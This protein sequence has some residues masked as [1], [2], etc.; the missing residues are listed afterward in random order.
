AILALINP[1]SNNSRK[2]PAFGLKVTQNDTSTYI[3]YEPFDLSQAAELATALP[4]PNRI[5]TLL[6]DGDPRSSKVIADELGAS[7][8]TIKAVL[9]KHKGMKWHL[10]GEGREAQWTVLSR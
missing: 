10:L 8:P 6:E 3:H 5:R 9:S 7:L 2:H 4:L 1:K